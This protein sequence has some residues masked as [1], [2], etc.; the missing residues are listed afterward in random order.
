LVLW[1][2][3]AQNPELV[4]PIS[5]KEDWGQDVAYQLSYKKKDG[6]YPTL[7]LGVETWLPVDFDFVFEAEWITGDKLMYGSA[8]QLMRELEDLNSKTWHANF[9][10]F[11]VWR[12]KGKEVDEPLEKGAQL[13]FSIF[14]QLAKNACDNRLI[15]KLDY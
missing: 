2:A 6:S 14:Y 7:I 5:S 1:A 8:F 3:Y 12:Q 11:A 15:M 10:Q 9:D 13:A 4:R